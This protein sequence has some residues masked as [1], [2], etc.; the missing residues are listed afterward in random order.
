MSNVDFQAIDR[1]ASWQLT[2]MRLHY[3]SRG[4]SYKL[5]PARLLEN[6]FEPCNRRVF[7]ISVIFAPLCVHRLLLPLKDKA[8]IQKEDEK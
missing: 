8:T 5:M 1:R 6:L 3:E 4:R 2:L 7:S